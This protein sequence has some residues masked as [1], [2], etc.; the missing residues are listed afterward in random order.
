MTKEEIDKAALYAAYVY[1]NPD[2]D[3][4]CYDPDFCEGFKSGVCWALERLWKEVATEEPPVDHSVLLC[5]DGVEIELCSWDGEDFCE[6]YGGYKF[7]PTHWMA[8][9]PLQ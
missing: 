1:A 6:V 4:P 9:P 7:R 8:I 5:H 3:C 2:E